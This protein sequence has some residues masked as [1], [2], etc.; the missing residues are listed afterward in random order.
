MAMT[1][2]FLPVMPALA[3]LASACSL[4]VEAAVP[5]VEITQRG[6]KMSGVPKAKLIGDISVS[7]SFAFSSSNTAWAKR[8]NSQVFVR[9][10]SVAGTGELSDLDFVKFARLTM[11]DPTDSKGSTEIVSYD[12][13]DEARSSS[14]IEVSMPAP[15]DITPLWSA[16]KTVI[17]L[18]LAGRLPE[19][20]WAVDVTLKLAGKITY[21]F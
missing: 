21:K 9:E 14:V 10:V 19:D 11:A 13:C 17:E 8:M 2:R 18:Q 7:S 1:L 4:S 12:R 6:L 5:E 20:D 3:A 15:I 16:D